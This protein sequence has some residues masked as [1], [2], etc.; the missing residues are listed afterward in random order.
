MAS[1]LENISSITVIARTTIAAVYRT[2][3]IIASLPILSYKKKAFPEALFHQLIQAMLHPDHETRI[4]AHQIFSVVLVPTS[5]SPLSHSSVADAHNFPRTLSRTVSVFSSSAALFEKLKRNPKEN[6]QEPNVAK[7]SGNGEQ[8]GVFNR[9]KS[10][11]SR[12]YSIRE[13][14][15]P[16][17]ES[18]NN[19]CNVVGLFDVFYF[20][21]KPSF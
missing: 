10:S 13:P 2:G 6:G 18:A 9:I 16:V 15:A 7:V 17:A 4:G 5:V 1:M 11:Y 14:P 12:V 20:I 8:S 21:V 3:Q 19:P